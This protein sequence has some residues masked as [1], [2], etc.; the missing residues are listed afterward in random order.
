MKNFILLSLVLM[1]G[2]ASTQ[3][4]NFAVERD[5]S[6]TNNNLRLTYEIKQEYSTEY[7]GMVG[8][9]IQNPTNAWIQ[10]DS[11]LLEVA[12]NDDPENIIVTG[13]ED[14]TTWFQSMNNE[15]L[16]ESYNRRAVWGTI[17]LG[18]T[19]G[20]A[21]S[22][23]ENVKKGAG[24]V[25][26]FSGEMMTLER[27]NLLRNEMNLQNYFPEDHLLRTPFRIPPGL[28]VNKWMVI[29]SQVKTED[30]LVH[31]LKM[32]VYFQDNDERNYDLQFVGSLSGY[33]GSWQGNLVRRLY[34]TQVLRRHRTA[35]RDY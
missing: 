33:T 19:L 3:L 18:A 22:K 23:D 28:T 9:A 2:C 10:V 31:G 13:G 15:K 27:F 35:Y 17:S 1:T 20:G 14:L 4:S 7:F 25:S 29:N 32:R 6:S 5:T 11:I 12:P 34:R 16:V 26:E 30:Q 24:L 8:F 21:L